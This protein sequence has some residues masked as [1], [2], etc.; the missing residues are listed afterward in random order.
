MSKAVSDEDIEAG[1]ARE[2]ARKEKQ[3]AQT[4]AEQLL[5]EAFGAT[6]VVP[7]GKTFA[8]SGKSFVNLLGDADVIEGYTLE[9][10][11]RNLIGVPFIITS[12]TVRDGVAKSKTELTNYVSAECV[13]ADSTTLAR[14]LDMGRISREQHGRIIPEEGIVINDGSTGIGRQLITY[15]DAKGIIQCPEG[16]EG[17]EAG[18]SRYDVYRAQWLKGYDPAIGDMRFELPRGL[19][20]PRGLRVSEYQS[21]LYGDSVTFYIA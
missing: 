7:V 16:P 8:P 1:I 18:E 4:S 15:L 19:A 20:C 10:E 6:E 11:K 5:G 17:G 14:L 3:A 12:V 21:A 2:N 13:V 9:T